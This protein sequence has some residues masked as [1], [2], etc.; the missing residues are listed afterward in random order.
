MA[1]TKNPT[2]SVINTTPATIPS[3]K[4]DFEALDLRQKITTT[5]TLTW[6]NTQIYPE[7]LALLIEYNTAEFE[8]VNKRPRPGFDGQYIITCIFSRTVDV[9]CIYDDAKPGIIKITDI[10]RAE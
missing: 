2:T 8:P 6:E 5:L 10:L 1:L 9:D 3:D 7:G 4:I